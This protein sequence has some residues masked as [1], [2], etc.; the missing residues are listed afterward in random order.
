MLSLLDLVLAA[1]AGRSHG[2]LSTFM[3][4][5]LLSVCLDSAILSEQ[6]PEAC[7]ARRAVAAELLNLVKE[8]S[9]TRSLRSRRTKSDE[10]R[11][12][13][14]PYP[15]ADHAADSAAKWQ[16]PARRRRPCCWCGK[17]GDSRGGVARAL[18]TM[19]HRAMTPAERLAEAR[20]R[21]DDMLARARRLGSGLGS[22]PPPG[23]PPPSRFPPPRRRASAAVEY[24]PT[25]CVPPPLRARR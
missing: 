21:R 23:R 5:V 9:S 17:R 12:A 13:G 1:A 25:R 10:A 24:A 2:C 8:Y 3:P 16:Q 15:S 18:L 7:C 14:P 19:P 20:A 4:A 22:G 6:A 11:A